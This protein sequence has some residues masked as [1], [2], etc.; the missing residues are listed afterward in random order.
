MTYRTASIGAMVSECE[1]SIHSNSQ[2]GP[3][4][5]PA[6]HSGGSLVVNL[7]DFA[8]SRCLFDFVDIDFAGVKHNSAEMF[9]ASMCRDPAQDSAATSESN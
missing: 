4:Q 9:R 7:D 2:G 8:F 5:P 6:L 3:A 1:T